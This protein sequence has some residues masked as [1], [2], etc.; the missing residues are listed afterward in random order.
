MCLV[1]KELYVFETEL[2]G[3]NYKT[4]CKAGSVATRARLVGALCGRKRKLI[5]LQVVDVAVLYSIF[6][7][8]LFSV[9][10]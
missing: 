5:N 9:F 10:F 2:F 4:N 6:L 1:I 7:M 8:E 3:L